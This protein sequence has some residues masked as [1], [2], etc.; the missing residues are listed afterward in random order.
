MTQLKKI[1]YKQW[2]RNSEAQYEIIMGFWLGCK[3][4]QQLKFRSAGILDK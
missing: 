1:V 2:G 4:T 3:L